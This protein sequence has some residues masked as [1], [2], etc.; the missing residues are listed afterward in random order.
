MWT[1]LLDVL[2]V[3][4]MMGMSGW[5]MTISERMMQ[6]LEDFLEVTGVD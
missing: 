2:Q 5:C 6:L 1:F 3:T 4:F